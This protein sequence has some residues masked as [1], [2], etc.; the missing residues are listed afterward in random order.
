MKKAGAAKKSAGI[1]DATVQLRTGKHWKEWFAILD[2]IG[3]K[4]KT[5]RELVIFLNQRYPR[6][7][8]WWE[9]MITVA[10]EQARG[11]RQPHQQASGFTA[12]VS[13]TIG[14][15]LTRLYR[16]WTHGSA[17]GRW[18]SEKNFTVRKAT[19]NKSLRIT[20]DG[21]KTNLEVHFLAKG[22]GKSQVVV[23]HTHLPDARAVARSKAYW[24][25]RLDALRNYL[26][27]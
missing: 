24:G 26:E 10:Y 22:A 2:H 23:Q 8:G 1:A 12:N 16:A 4:K 15:P 6:L 19:R 5:H 3:G 27:K 18:L 21:G 17:R 20:W 14:A 13:K 11:L 7:G 9:Q 25:Q